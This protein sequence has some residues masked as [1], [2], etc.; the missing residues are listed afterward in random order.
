MMRLRITRSVY[1]DIDGIRL[2]QFQ[3]GCV[4]EFGEQVAAVM[5]SE[6]WAELADEPAVVSNTPLRGARFSVGPAP[7][8]RLRVGGLPISIAVDQQRRAHRK[9]RG[10]RR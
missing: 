3:V 4:Y 9:G 10:G 5:L 1:G 7:R 6:G 8:Q 2:D